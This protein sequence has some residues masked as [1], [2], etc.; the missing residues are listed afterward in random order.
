[1]GLSH[2]S[3]PG[4]G[5]APQV[6][7]GP[8]RSLNTVYQNVSGRPILVL[9]SGKVGDVSSAR[10]AV[11][12]VSS[13]N[14]PTVVASEANSDAGEFVRFFFSV[15]VPHGFFYR[16]RDNAG[17]AVTVLSWKELS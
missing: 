14:P 5:D 7:S 10:D 12:Q 9:V 17:S 16:L 11:F 8:A 2:K 4:L 1:M 13:V 6:Y 15:I 3:S